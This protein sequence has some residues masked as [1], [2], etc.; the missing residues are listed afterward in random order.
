MEEQVP[1]TSNR[2]GQRAMSRALEDVVLCGRDFSCVRGCMDVVVG[3]ITCQ[4]T[5]EGRLRAAD[6]YSGGKESGLM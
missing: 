5:E 2:T 1:R 6:T 4:C 3:P